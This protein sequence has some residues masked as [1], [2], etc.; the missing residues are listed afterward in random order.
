M[1]VCLVTV[2]TMGQ[3]Q[4][5]SII[6]KKDVAQN[7]GASNYP[8]E[9]IL[10]RNDI[11]NNAELDCL[12][13]AIYYESATQSIIGKEAVAMVILNR[14]KKELKFFPNTICKIVSQKI[15]NVCQFSYFCKRMPKPVG[16]NWTDSIFVANLALKNKLS[17]QTK[18]TLSTALFFH[19]K[20]INC[21]WKH[22]NSIKFVSRVEDHLFYADRTVAF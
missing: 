19:S 12:S 21:P 5:I 7:V 3:E 2:T 9:P 11:D 10:A 13:K 4:D 16:K 1:F 18:K 8:F 15:H 20:K 17:R 22:N 6:L 14:K